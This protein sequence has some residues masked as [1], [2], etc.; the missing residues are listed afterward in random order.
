MNPS[1]PA[2]SQLNL[3][4]LNPSQLSAVENLSGPMLILAGAGSGKTRVVT[5]RIARLIQER[6]AAPEQILAVT[7]TNKAAKE[8]QSRVAALL[9]S[10]SSVGGE[11]ATSVLLSAGE[12]LWITTF[13]SA[14]VRILRRTIHLL[15]YRRGFT[16]Y[17]DGDQLAQVK[18][19]MVAL[20][21][22]DKITPPK[23][24]R[25]RINAAK[26]LG[27]DAEQAAKSSHLHF[28]QITVD[29]Y[30]RYE[31]EM[32]RSN[33]LDFGDLLLKVLQIFT[34]Y[35][36]ILDEYRDH[37]RSVLVDEYQDTNHIQYMITKLLA[38][39][40]RNLCVVGDEDQS[41]YSWRGADISNI[42]DFEKDFPEAKVVKLEENYRSSQNI[43]TAASRLIAHNAIRKNKTLFTQN[44]AGEKISIR[45]ERSEYDEARWV[46]RQIQTLA[47]GGPWAWS[48]FA[49]FY[50]TNAQSR[51]LEEQLRLHS[52]PYRLI[53][54]MRFYE[55]QEVKDALGY[56]KLILNPADD[57]SF[58]RVVN[59]PTRGIGKATI[60][61][62]EELALQQKISMFEATQGALDHRVFPS[63]PAGR[64]RQFLH[65]IEEL[66]H[67]KS[68]GGTGQ[69]GASGTSADATGVDRH[70]LLD[71]FN[72]VMDRT[73]Y[74]KRLRQE[75]SPEA[76]AR[77]E[78]LEELS[79]ALAYFQRERTDASLQNFLE[80]MALVS[81]VD[82]MEESPHTVTLM[83]LHL[84]K[85]LEF[86]VVFIVGLEENLFPSG[87]SANDDEHELEEERRLAYVGMTRAEKKLHL[88]YAQTRKVWGQ[89]QSY[90][91]SRFLKEIPP[92]LVSFTTAADRPKFMSRNAGSLATPPPRFRSSPDEDFE[93]QGFPDEV[94]EF[95]RGSKVRH[96]TFGVGTVYQTEGSGD[97]LKVSVLFADQTIKKFVA[98]YARLEKVV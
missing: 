78:N 27:L 13:H 38:Q 53:G 85:G 59:T 65:L 82:Q 94:R 56:L 91:P 50:R 34:H 60:E 61:K 28:D 26:T 73:E 10:P 31:E 48:D 7:F 18:K 1:P 92:E 17:D 55:R 25:H 79:N 96:P 75:D 68:V 97:Q 62:I 15:D 58:K 40:H 86:P 21:L 93:I 66:R 71:F 69:V 84:S 52:I 37:F 41:I 29:V 22:S 2:S 87:R 64:L 51:V 98:K 72:L 88:S 70:S 20:N 47:A 63:R 35:P 32:K 80:E 14:C 9:G 54:G 77:I 42:M 46:T 43:V 95:A 19:V 30:S 36:A 39:E 44:P 23:S 4:T 89:D 16:I 83:T 76:N 8:M 45:E 74:V 81:D 6:Q 24:L 49:V 33:A 5:H 11:A 12:P 90:P 67:Q 57:I 3:S